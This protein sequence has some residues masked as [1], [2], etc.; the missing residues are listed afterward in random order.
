MKPFGIHYI[1]AGPKYTEEA[2]ISAKSARKHMPDIGLAISTTEPVPQDLFDIVEVVTPP[3]FSNEEIT[4]ESLP[5]G[6]IPDWIPESDHLTPSLYRWRKTLK[7][8]LIQNIPFEK[9]FYLDSDT[10]FCAP[11]Y[12]VFQLLDKFQ[13]AVTH[14]EARIGRAID[15]IPSSFPEMG[16]GA[17]AY[18][19]CPGV[20]NLFARWHE[21]YLEDLAASPY[22]FRADQP[23]LRQSL[24]ES[25]LRIATLPPEYNC[26]FPYPFFACGR[27]KILHGHHDNFPALDALLN[28]S[29]DMRVIVG[30]NYVITNSDQRPLKTVFLQ[31]LQSLRKR[32]RRPFV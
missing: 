7:P 8:R 13:V 4:S 15:S 11:I 6:K 16:G 25:E 27:I 23:T 1:V 2:I 26:R 17:I 28:A 24:Y 21:L 18:R 29:E 5:E 14:A 19:R 20:A 32:I 22:W 31:K 3:E 12:D 30:A 10:Y 9:T